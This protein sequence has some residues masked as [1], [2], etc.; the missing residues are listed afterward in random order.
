MIEFLL[1]DLDDTVLDFHKAE[2]LALSRTLSELGVEP[3]EAVLRLY[4]E[5]NQW[6]WE[7]LELGAMSRE[8]VLLGRFDMLFQRLGRKALAEECAWRYEE[9]LARGHFFM[10]GALETLEALR[11]RYRMF[12][13]SNGTAKVQQGRLTS[14]KLYP[15]FEEIFISQEIGWDKPAKEFYDCCFAQIP[16]FD[17][18][19]ALAVGDSLTSDIR[20]GANAG[21]KTVWVNPERRP[22]TGIKPDYEIENLAGLVALLESLETRC[23]I[24]L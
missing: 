6:H 17:R 14:A 23:L 20:G 21:V 15:F 11:G 3:E 8:Q 13:M 10:P 12:L 7:Q 22:W 9:N 19:K 2:R 16:G 18:E 4:H 5:I 24:V 1:L